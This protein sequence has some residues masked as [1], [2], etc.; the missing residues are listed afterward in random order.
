MF[1]QF[2]QGKPTQGKPGIEEMRSRGLDF[3]QLKHELRA[4]LPKVVDIRWIFR[5]NCL[6]EVKEVISKDGSC[7][8]R[9]Y[10]MKGI[11]KDVAADVISVEV[12]YDDDILTTWCAKFDRAT[13]VV[14]NV[15][16]GNID[17]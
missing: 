4:N 14:T 12:S 8:D 5:F 15:N 7:V 3:C 11:V 9:S 16:Y 13:Q 2:F 10:W 17:R 1:R 6:D